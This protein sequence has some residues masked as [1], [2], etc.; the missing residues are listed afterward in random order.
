M[1]CCHLL[2]ATGCNRV[3]TAVAEAELAKARLQ[4]QLLRESSRKPSCN[5]GR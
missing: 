5:R 4:P 3:A 1:S 2:V